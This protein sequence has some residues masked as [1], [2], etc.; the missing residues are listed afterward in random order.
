MGK[1]GDKACT[2]KRALN[3]IKKNMPFREVPS[4]PDS[5]PRNMRSMQRSWILAGLKN[6][7]APV[8]IWLG[9]TWEMGFEG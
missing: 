9:A 3:K 5:L 4:D 7:G 8:V 6:M 1:C 2:G